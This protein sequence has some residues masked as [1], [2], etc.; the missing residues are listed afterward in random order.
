M[1]SDFPSLPVLAYQI[2]NGETS[3]RALAETAAANHTADDLGAYKTWN[4]ARALDLAEHVDALIAAGYDTGPL[5]GMPVSVKDLFGVPGLPVFAG[6][7]SEFSPEWQRAGP[8]MARLLSQLGVVM[9]KTHTV[10]MAFGG[11]GANPHWTPPRNPWGDGRHVPGGSSS[12]A[13]VSLAEGSALVA[14]GTDTAGSVR[15]PASLTGAVGL[16]V[17]H[18]RWSQ[19]GI[20][21]LS[22]SFDTPGILC[23]TAEDIA[24]AFAAMDPASRPIPQI[25]PSGLRIGV[26]GG[27]AA[28]GVDDD[29]AAAVTGAL[30]RL[31]RSGAVLSDAPLPHAEPALA[32]FRQGGLAASELAAFLESRMPE[33]IVRLD[34]AV[35]ARIDAAR[36][37]TAIDYLRR[38]AEFARMSAE[39]ASSAFAHV[40]L[41]ACPTVAVSPPRW[42]EIA[43]PD[44][45]AR[46][47]MA[48]LRNTA[49]GNLLG[50][51]AITL[52]VGID[53]NGIPVG[54]ML[55]AQP[56]DEE[57]LI[58]AAV[59]AERLWDRPTRPVSRS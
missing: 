31:E 8:V 19:D 18:G 5:M 14:F 37:L 48:V 13:G 44:S 58:A 39:T 6:T 36:G 53:R 43:T 55:M 51:C 11:L 24:F 41:L 22:P 3:A 42:D 38:K 49:I 15:I 26:L 21:P 34:P 45:Y 29:I 56:N 4:G 17:T 59:A 47:N 50:L 16:K 30:S 1:P 12:G 27:V 52:P 20:V 28:E 9:G 54:L 25:S 40:D 23:R 32:L 46:A 35:Q 33:R 57:R 10:E 2:R 7:D